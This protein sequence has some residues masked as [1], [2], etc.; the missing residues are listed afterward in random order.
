MI[1]VVRKCI[2]ISISSSHSHEAKNL[3]V[4]IH[5]LLGIDNNSSETLDNYFFIHIPAQCIFKYRKLIF[6]Y[7]P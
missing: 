5:R 3:F 4:V 1:K 7:K 2:L 6:V